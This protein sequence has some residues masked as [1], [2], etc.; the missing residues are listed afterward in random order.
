MLDD[1]DWTPLH[2]AA[3]SGYS[4]VIACLL[5]AGAGKLYH[6]GIIRY[7]IVEGKSNVARFL[8]RCAFSYIRFSCSMITDQEALILNLNLK[9]SIRNISSFIYLLPILQQEY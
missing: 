8:V 4:D 3:K 2:Y 5:E 9:N 7:N 1:F 6:D